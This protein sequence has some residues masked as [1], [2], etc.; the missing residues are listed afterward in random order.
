MGQL[1]LLSPIRLVL[2]NDIIMGRYGK[3]LYGDH[4]CADGT[5]K[6][7]LFLESRSQS[8]TEVL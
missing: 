7:K 8:G 5:P 4:P 6:I 3:E 2:L 1:T